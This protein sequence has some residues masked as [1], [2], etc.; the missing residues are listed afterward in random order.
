MDRAQLGYPRA[1]V[2]AEREPWTSAYDALAASPFA[3]LD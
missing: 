3:S 1:M 2:L